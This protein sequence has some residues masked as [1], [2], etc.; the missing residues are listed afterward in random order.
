MTELS[1][2][3]RV[4][5]GMVRLGR[6]TGYD[7]KSLVDN[8][9]R[10]FWA[11]SYGQIYPE[12]KRLE[13]AGLITAAEPAGGRRRTEYELTEEGEEALHDWLTSEEEPLFELRDEGMLKLF[14]ADAL[15][16]E[17]TVAQLERTQARHRRAAARLREI[18]RAVLEADGEKTRTSPYR[19]L[20]A[21]IEFHEFMAAGYHRLREAV[22]AAAAEE[23]PR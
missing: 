4:I 11:A 1:P 14:F 12:L 19:T 21:G 23:V 7:I 22:A 17:E 20:L 6:R 8:S 13:E 18:Q 3:A 9:T 5:L 10:F 16:P 15:R 2:T